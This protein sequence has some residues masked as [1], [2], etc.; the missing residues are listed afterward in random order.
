MSR[1]ITKL[2]MIRSSM[3]TAV[4]AAFAAAFAAAASPA[5]AQDIDIGE[6]EP[7]ED[8]SGPGVSAKPGAYF[9]SRGDTGLGVE[10]NATYGITVSPFVIAPGGRF[11]A[12]L[13][14]DGAVTGMPVAEARLPIGGV[15]P[16]AK[17]GLGVG[18]ATGPSESSV[19]L[20]A[21]GGVDVHVSRDVTVGVDATYEAV[22]G[23][24]FNALSIGPRAGLRY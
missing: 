7:L 14:D 17:A 2:R 24:G 5:A 18:H 3:S 12:Y 8:D 19:A 16:Y 20:M 4:A 22:T 11:A 13:G 21:G 6:R 15:V 9:P 10:A 1:V 23:T